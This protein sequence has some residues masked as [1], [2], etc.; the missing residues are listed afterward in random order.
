MEIL[1][2]SQIWEETQPN[3]LSPFHKLN[4]GHS[5][6][7]TRKSNYENFLDLPNF[8]GFFYFVTNIFFK[9]VREIKFLVL[10]RT[11]ALQT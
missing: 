2:T 7:K 6:P 8:T 5:C 10:T 11:A 1:G 4:F 9:I 3:S